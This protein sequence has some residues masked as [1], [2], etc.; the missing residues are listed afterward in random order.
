MNTKY[1]TMKKNMVK[2]ISLTFILLLGNMKSIAQ[3][4][5]VS[6]IVSPA[7]EYMWWNKNLSIDNMPLYGGKIGFGFGPLFE[8]RAFYFGGK[9]ANAMVRPLN[10]ATDKTWTK[11]IKETKLDITKYGG[12]LKL[13]LWRGAFFAPYFTV[14]GGVQQMKYD[15][16]KTNAAQNI[17]NMKDE[18]LFAT[19]GLGAKFNISNR[20]TLSLEAKNTL[21]NASDGSYLM[22]PEYNK[23]N[24]GNHLYNWTAAATLD[25]YLGGMAQNNKDAISREYR[26]LFSGGLKGFKFVIEPAMAY[27]DFNKEL[28]MTDTYLVGANAGFD[29]SSLVGIRGFYYQANK[30]ADKLSLAFNKQLALYGG[31][32]ITRLNFPRG[33]TPYLQ[34]G[35]GYMKVG[36]KYADKKGN[37]TAESSP[38]VFGGAGIEIPLSKYIALFGTANAVFTSEKGIKEEDIQNTD[39]ILTSMMYQ[40]GL[41][42]NI[43][44]AANGEKK[45]KQFLYQSL[46]QQRKASNEK[47][48]ELRAQYNEQIDDY[49]KKIEQYDEQV[50]QYD[51]QIAQYEIRIN[52]LKADYENKIK[53]LDQDF[54]Q[55]LKAND[56]IKIAE[57]ARLKDTNKQELENIEREEMATK[58]KLVNNLTPNNNN[59]KLTRSQLNDLVKQVMIEAKQYVGCNE[60]THCNAAHTHIQQQTLPTQTLMPAAQSNDTK[61]L[62]KEIRILNEK[63]NML[64]AQRNNLTDVNEYNNN[65]IPATELVPATNKQPNQHIVTNKKYKINKVGIFTGWGFGDLTT[66]NVGVRGYMPISNT[67]LDFVPEL[68]AAI[69]NNSGIG[70]SGNVVY[71]IKIKALNNITPYIGAGLGIFH[72]NNT[73]VGSNL[74]IGANTNLWGGKLFIDYAAR[75]L[76]KQNQ[77]AVGYSFTF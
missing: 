11:N 55:A 66:W 56:T 19:L 51:E 58:R 50:A 65:S 73:H 69:A 57:I 3:V 18:Q 7:A 29:L 75:C 36:N 25:F 64:I 20:T 22:K 4:N 48:N 61:Q 68:Y 59:V 40:A 31:N 72:G 71:N 62:K 52:K 27:L 35:G 13:N 38:F 46:D 28:P 26:K 47:I 21:F 12:E 76:T 74:I 32:L 34:L 45:Y 23:A 5:D 70:V 39:H 9:D 49:D 67:N 6:F 43:G 1:Q 37:T 54:A 60:C 44:K 42:F 14:G 77:L 24:G 10:W 63:L 41:R 33:I 53:Q 2:F 17:V 16:S 15:V 8:L 30:D